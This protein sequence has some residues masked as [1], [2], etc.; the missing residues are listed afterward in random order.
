[1]PVPANDT[2]TATTISGDTQPTHG[3]VKISGDKVIYTLDKR[4]GGTNTLKTA[5]GTSTATVSVTVA[6]TRN[7]GQPVNGSLNEKGP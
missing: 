4:L 3:T 1:V 2:G 7:P 6:R 5:C